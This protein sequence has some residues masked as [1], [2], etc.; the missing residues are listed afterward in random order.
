MVR[1][2]E[3]LAQI[4]SDCL[5]LSSTL[6]PDILREDIG[7]RLDLHWRQHRTQHGVLPSIL[8]TF[9]QDDILN[10]PNI[11]QQGQVIL[12]K[13]QPSLLEAVHETTTRLTFMEKWTDNL[14]NF[15]N[16][17]ILGGSLSYG[18]FVNVRGAYPRGSDL[19]IILLTRNIPHT[20]NI[21][22]L[23]PTPLG[24]SLNDQSIFHTRLDEFNRMRRKKTAQMISHKFLLPQQ[25]FDISMHFMDQD[26]FH[27]LCHPT[28]IEHSPR[29]F[30]DF[31]SAKFPHQT[32][33]QKDTHGDPFPF[34]VNEHE[35]INGFI[36]RTQ[37]CGFSNGNFVPGIYHNLMAPMFELFYG[38]TD[39]QNQIECFRLYLFSST[40]NDKKNTDGDITQSHPRRP[41]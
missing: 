40:H 35:V 31:K 30:L 38:D 11:R 36:A 12:D 3:S 41:L 26:I 13:Q 4:T 16:G 27:Q 33:N 6:H 34:S 37:I 5:E 22:R 39:C 24:F 8:R 28:D 21:N 19:D 15:I 20:I 2:S 18:R 32:M 17:V 10:I 1:N 25:G 29:Y 9:S 7:Y 23:L 14:L